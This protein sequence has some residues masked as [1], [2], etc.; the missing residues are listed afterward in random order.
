MIPEPLVGG[1]YQVN[2]GDHKRHEE[3]YNESVILKSFHEQLFELF[4][5]LQYIKVLLNVRFYDEQ[6]LLD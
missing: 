3:P 1:R 6:N 2:S 4:K 5:Q